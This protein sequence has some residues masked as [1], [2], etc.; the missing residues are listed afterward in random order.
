[1]SIIKLAT[2][3]FS[4]TGNTAVHLNPVRESDSS[5]GWHCREILKKD[6]GR[7]IVWWE[8]DPQARL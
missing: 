4:R 3:I 1:M 5:E 8:I 7:C 6:Q 2:E